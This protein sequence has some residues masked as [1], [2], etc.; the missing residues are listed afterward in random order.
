V[1]LAG[2]IAS[3]RRGDVELMGTVIPG[4]GHDSGNIALF[5]VRW[6]PGGI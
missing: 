3:V 4:I 5:F 1:P 2:G 6:S